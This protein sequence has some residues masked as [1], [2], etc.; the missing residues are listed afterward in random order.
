MHGRTAHHEVEGRVDEW[1]RGRVA[2]LQEDV[3][4]A[5]VAQ[6]GRADREELGREVDADHLTHLRRCDLGRVRGSAGDVQ[7][8]HA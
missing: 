6:A 2:L 1:Q 8:E 5:G 4:D 3:G 7:Y